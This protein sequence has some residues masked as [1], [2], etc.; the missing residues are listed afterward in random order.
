M[1]PPTDFFAAV[2]A[3]GAIETLDVD[4]MRLLYRIEMSGEEFYFGIADRIGDAQAAE[5]L[6]RNGREERG[7][8]ERLRKAIALKL[9]RP[10][11]PEAADRAPLAIPLPDEIP[12]SLLGLIVQGELDGDVGYQRWADREA[13]PE[14]QKLLRQNGRE[15]TR[16]GERVREVIALLGA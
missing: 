8:A 15:E 3:I 7:H 2:A 6:R 14:V 13:D 1:T 16:H 9:G 4:A 12:G 5:L 11:E 10:F